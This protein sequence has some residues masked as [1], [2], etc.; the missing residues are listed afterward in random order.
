V[1]GIGQ[2]SQGEPSIHVYDLHTSR[3][4]RKLTVPQLK[5]GSEF[6]SMS[7]SADGK[8]L[9]AQSGAPDWLLFYFPWE[10]GKALAS[11]CSSPSNDLPVYHATINPFDSGEMMV[12]GK[13][14][15]TIYRFAENTL[16][17][18]P[19]AVP[20]DLH[21][22]RH[23]WVSIDRV[24]VVAKQ[25]TMLLIQAGQVIHTSEFPNSAQISSIQPTKYGF[26]V[27]G[28]GGTVIV[29][30]FLLE[31]QDSLHIHQ[32]IVLPD[33]S[34]VVTGLASTSS[35]DTLLIELSTNQILK[36][37]LQSPESSDQIQSDETKLDV[38]M[39][40]YHT[41]AISGMD[42]CIRKPIL[43]TCS[44]DKSVR[45]WNYLT[46]V[47][48]LMKSFGDEPQSVALH[49]SGLYLLVGFSDKL[50]LMNILMDDLRPVRE[51]PIR[52]CKECRFSNGGHVF[53]AA[54][55][56]IVQIY[57]TWTFENLE[58]LKGHNGKIRSLYWTPDDGNLVSAGSDGAVYT[59]N[60]RT[61]K[62]EHE[63]ILKSCGYFEAVCS[64]NGKAMFAVGTDKMI[65]EITESTITKEFEAN[66]TMTQ[67]ALSNS[68]RMLFVGTHAGTIRALRFPFGDQHDFQE[69]Q[70][71]AGPVSQL[72][73]SSDDQFLFSASEDGCIYMFRLTDKEDRG[74]KKDK[75]SIFA[76]EILITRS[77]LE[78]KTV[79]MAEIQR[80]L[81]ELK[82]EHEYQLRLKDMNFNEKLK[83]ITENFSQE[84]E[85]LKVST[86]VLR[87]EK[88]KEDV[89]HQEQIQ[90][91]KAK[92]LSELHVSKAHLGIRHQE[93]FAADDRI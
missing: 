12:T 90:N 3:K 92:H 20:P 59:W 17:T 28:T 5:N 14:F 24:M 57:S 75:P 74:N 64:P 73:V 83:E 71:H 49:P 25:G 7:F 29:Y 35:D 86:S 31:K 48:E 50:R 53:A 56:N 36:T 88:E 76:D 58:N 6:V 70:A 30:N 46:G 55:G 80:Q 77:D 62:R 33:A 91:L 67:V 45:I 65:K 47:C 66:L 68:G 87:T 2:K 69:H 79:L 26:A 43:V 34:I 15:A 85:A 51:F 81:D 72:R 63:H 1:F 78:E 40:S 54:H 16:R 89:K 82:L 61:M 41:G 39:E 37:T 42:V 10:K 4:R 93:Q 52:A 84:I 60:M 32:K 8:F 11:V 27:G 13:G 18:I 23:C 21:Y 44:A 22:I 19:L 9:V 38:F